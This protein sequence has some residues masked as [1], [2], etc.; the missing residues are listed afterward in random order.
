LD[1][2]TE[3]QLKAAA[4]I[5][6]SWTDLCSHFYSFSFAAPHHAQQPRLRDRAGGFSVNFFQQRRTNVGEEHRT[7][8][9]RGVRLTKK[10][11]VYK[12]MR[13][14]ERDKE[15]EKEKESERG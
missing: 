1:S 11:P 14:R 13:E 7:E 3:N 5:F 10:E 4:N 8:G 2:G 12:R 6:F 9:E 15:R